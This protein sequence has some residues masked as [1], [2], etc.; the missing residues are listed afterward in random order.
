[1]PILVNGY[2]GNPFGQNSMD[3]LQGRFI[4]A[5]CRVALSGSYPTGG[6]VLDFTNGGVNSAV[7]PLGR[8][9]EN[10]DVHEHA[11]STSTF[12]GTGCYVAV[13]GIPGT[14]AASAWKLKFLQAGGT[15][16]SAGAYSGFSASPL[17]DVIELE[18]TWAR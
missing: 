13:I 1:M 6:D 9:I 8:V 17:T 5:Y 15:E 16:Q 4:K 14:T 18:I 7:P 12:V 11:A 3:G 2:D 10:I